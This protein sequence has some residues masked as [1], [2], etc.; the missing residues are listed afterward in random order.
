[1]NIR[2]RLKHILVAPVALL[3]ALLA[4]APA[5]DAAFTSGYFASNSRLSTG[6]WV[7]I[8]ITESG[9]HQI[10]DDELRAMGFS[11]PERVA[12]C[13]FPAVGL[14]DY[15]LTETT[16]DDVPVLPSV[17]HNGKLIFYGEADVRR[18]VAQSGSLSSGVRYPVSLTR[19]HY[20]D[21]GTYFLTDAV[22]PV[23]PEVI[24]IM[25][26]RYSA[27]STGYGMVHI[28]EELDHS[29]QLGPFFFG[30]SLVEEPSQTYSFAMPQMVSGGN[31]YLQF[32]TACQVSQSSAIYVTAPSGRTSSVSVSNLSA[33]H[34]VYSGVRWTTVDHPMASADGQYSLTISGSRL[35]SCSYGR[36]DYVTATY[37]RF[38]TFSGPQQLVVYGNLNALSGI[39]I[40]TEKT[41]IMVWD[42]TDPNAPRSFATTL[43]THDEPEE[44][45]IPVNPD[46]EPGD[47][48]DTGGEMN[49]G[50]LM[51]HRADGDLGEVGGEGE[52]TEE[53]TPAIRISSPGSFNLGAGTAAYV[54]SFDPDAELPGVESLGEV[55]NQNLHSMA[56]P[57]MVIIAA[58]EFME[59]AERLAATHREHDGMD[60]A[61]VCQDDIYNEF[62]SG[63]PHITA[64]RRFVKMLYD[65]EPGK[66]KS[67]LLFGSAST[68]NRD[69]A[70][71]NRRSFRSTHIPVMLQ[72]DLSLAGHRSKSFSTDAFV[73][74]MQE[75]EE[76]FDIYTAHMD[77]NVGRIPADNIGDARSTVNK[78]VR[79]IT[80][81]PAT[82]SLNSALLMCDKGDANGHMADAIGLDSIISEVSPSTNVYKAFNTIFPRKS[83]KAPE[84]NQYAANALVKGVAYWA[85]SG[86]SKPE[87]FAAEPLWSVDMVNK[88]DYEVPPVAVFATCR[89]L[90]FD[91][92]GGSVAEAALF[93]ERGGAIAVIGAL[94]EV[95][96]EKNQVLNKEIGRAFF[97]AAEGTTVGDV[98]RTARRSSVPEDENTSRDLIINTLSYN[99][100]GDPEVPVRRPQLQVKLQSIDGTDYD[101][102]SEEV[103]ID[104]SREVVLEGV[105]TDGTGAVVDNFDGDITLSLF[106]AERIASVVN[107]GTG[108]GEDSYL[109]VEVPYD[110]ELIFEAVA[111]VQGGHFTFRSHL[112]RPQ[113][114]GA[115]RLT[116]IASSADHSMQAS[117]VVKNLNVSHEHVDVELT[118]A[119]VPEITEMYL[120]TPDFEDG[121]VTSGTPTLCATV[122]PNIYGIA[123]NSALL[124]KSAS[125]ILDGGSRSF[126]EVA[127]ALEPDA[128][129]GAS[130]NVPL[131]DISDGPHTLTLKVM[132]YAGQSAERSLHFTAVNVATDAALTVDEYP[133]QS[134]ATIGLEHSMTGTVS[135]RVVVKD[136]TGSV[137][138]TAGDVSF[139]YSWNLRGSDG[140]LVPEGPYTV[141]SYVTDGS[142]YGSAA[143]VEVVVR[144]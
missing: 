122:A 100:V 97:S 131:S 78:T 108:F 57:R 81:P 48:G 10:T 102:E 2:T 112:P 141:E 9:M 115:N 35:N 16:P 87:S 23:A 19:N 63:T 109:G 125:L 142:H 123:G 33:E 54:L 20:A 93:R 4:G 68:D 75:D 34:Y 116:F 50:S 84:L 73:G 29:H 46:P 92:P 128:Q 66:L 88:T 17:H 37:Q 111:E 53:E 67:V 21:F 137:V 140:N 36:I 1:M 45:E 12:V 39:E 126:T 25:D 85:Y 110:D 96:K 138:F 58:S 90:Y 144:R 79:Y 104:N 94:R 113:R 69:K 32:Q 28:E 64:L 65:R 86:H 127:L 98:F 62:S 49:I 105:I 6:K 71:G 89:A 114:E 135:G 106:D 30:R 52:G 61:V 70:G 120:D 51:S 5:A 103:A 24:P 117:G 136:G 14:S 133:A 82:R 83:N 47:G 119:T 101:A 107:V 26:G 134:V 129:G 15:R 80:N 130:V 60:V 11:D 59:E 13:G 42:V 76:D 18:R 31:V 121:D 74:M 55:A 77:V 27:V 41:D 99:L 22:A 132:N 139:P 118:D 91:H 143:P 3:L 72:E 8:K 43:V 95:Y 124:G 38:N 56:T 40:P 44:P 7:K